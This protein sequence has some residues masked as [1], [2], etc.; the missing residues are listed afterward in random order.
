MT[1]TLEGD[2][3]TAIVDATKQQNVIL[4]VLR[5]LEI[6][7]LQNYLSKKKIK[8]ISDQQKLSFL[9]PK[10]HILQAEGRT[11]IKKEH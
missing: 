6:S 2:L 10:V 11:E 7:A 4:R 8:S 5:A 9:L 1:I 3:L